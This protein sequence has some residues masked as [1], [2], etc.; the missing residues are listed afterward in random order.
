MISPGR[1]QLLIRKKAM[2]FDRLEKVLLPY[3]KKLKSQERLRKLLG[4]K[5]VDRPTY[6]RYIT[7]PVKRFD[8]RKNAFAVMMPGNPYGHEFKERYLRRTGVD[9]FSK[10]L[11]QSALE[12]EDRLAQALSTASWRLCTDYKPET[13]SLTPADGRFEVTD[14]AW[15]SRIIKKV[16][17]FFGAEMVRITRVD[18]RWVYQ[19]REIPHRY[20]IIAVVPHQYPMNNTAPSFF[21]GLSVANTYSRLKFITTQ[22]ADFIRQL[23]HDAMYRETLGW[24][25][26]MLMVPMAI[27]AGIG[28]FA[29][30]GRVMS[31]EFGVNMRLKA[32]TT[33]L[34]LQV[35]RPI[36]F[37]A[38]EFCMA[39]ENCALYC[40]ANALAFGE[41][42]DPPDSMFNNPGYKKWYVR[43][44]RCL[45][46]WMTN[47]KKWI[48]CGGRCIA[49]CPW[50]K[51]LNAFHN[52]V[53]FTAV[54][55]PP[56]I[57]KMLVWADRLVYERKKRIVE[58]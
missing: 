6:E 31:P 26:E 25:P 4:V 32:V 8:S 1:I 42:T 56:A 3:E 22:L 24:D 57:K 2:H 18:Q 13:L 40:P 7:G 11:P 45:F 5:E 44:D 38:H 19:D 28:E 52:L 35:D 17:M 20:A 33:D 16:G 37:Q 9:Y 47:R 12:P 21:S 15:M 54:H 50:N 53:R 48:T 41:P 36:S 46:F 27:D 58:K 34:P 23:G 30:T 39:C 29:R 14:P 55:S 43:A 51:P 10:P 49:V